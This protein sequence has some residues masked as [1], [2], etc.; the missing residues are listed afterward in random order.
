MKNIF[1]V[2]PMAGTGKGIEKLVK[3]ISRISDEMGICSETYITKAIGDGENFARKMAIETQG[4]EELHIFACGG[5]GTN[6][7]VINGVYGFDHVACGCLPIGTGN[8]FVRNFPEAGNFMDIKA[9]LLGKPIK[10]DLIK[11]S[12]IIDGIQQTRYC[13]NMFNIGFDCNV[14]DL[15]A[16]LKTYPFLAGS[17]AY[18]MAILGTFIKKKGAD[19]RIEANGQLIED[20]EV[21][22]CAV[23]NGSYCGGGL[24]SS[25]QASITDGIFDLNII[26]DVPRFTFLKLF[27]S[28]TKGTHMGKKGIEKLFVAIRCKNAKISPR[29]G[30][31]RLCV[32]GEISSV[33]D[34]YMEIVEDAINFLM[35]ANL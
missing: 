12:G 24:K 19:L 16:K 22:L 11:Y 2:N 25:P 17:F 5:D 26:Y 20:G 28:Y 9:Q 10:S 21:L 18:M 6:N 1:V 27:P 35:P 3:G 34:I 23:S 31:F 32:D 13:A 15:T 14:V 4:I 29:G 33:G 30:E 7:E 8:D